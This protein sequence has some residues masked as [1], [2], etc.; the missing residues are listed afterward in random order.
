M[1]PTY[2]KS[3][4]YGKTFIMIYSL[5]S[6][7]LFLVAIGTLSYIMIIRLFKIVHK[8]WLI[9]SLHMLFLAKFSCAMINNFQIL[10]HPKF[11]SWF[12]FH[13][14][15]VLIFFNIYTFPNLSPS[16]Y[17]FIFS[18]ILPWYHSS[19]FFLSTFILFL[20]IIILLV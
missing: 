13:N 19:S 8:P 4:C 5:F 16:L 2:F 17:I 9:W 7:Q 1:V 10:M 14:I 11:H 3:W 18:N 6:L 20:F 12:L 15:F